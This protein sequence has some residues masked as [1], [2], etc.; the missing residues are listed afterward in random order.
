VASRDEQGDER[1]GEVGVLHGRREEMPLH[2]MHPDQGPGSRV[3]ERF[4]VQDAD[5]ERAHEPRSLGDGD[6]V[7]GAPVDARLREGP[8][9]DG[10]EGGEVRAAGQLGDHAAEHAVHVLRQDDEA[11]ELRRPSRPVAHE[12]RGRGLVAGG[13]DPQDDVSHGRSSA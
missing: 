5:Q 12:H 3:R 8:L 4:R 9:H 13:L 1:R 11:R 2:V 10:G 6:R 7:H